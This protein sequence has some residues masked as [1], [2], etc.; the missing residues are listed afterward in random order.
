MKN[1]SSLA[2][3]KFHVPVGTLIDLSSVSEVPNTQIN[4]DPMLFCESVKDLQGIDFGYQTQYPLLYTATEAITDQIDDNKSNSSIQKSSKDS[5][6][7]IASLISDDAPLINFSDEVSIQTQEASF[8]EFQ[9]DQKSLLDIVIP[10]GSDTEEYKDKNDFFEIVGPLV[11]LSSDADNSV[12][13]P[14]GETNI[15]VTK[16]C[17]VHPDLVG[18]DFSK[19]DTVSLD[20]LSSGISVTE[21]SEETITD[22][23]VYADSISVQEIK[24]SF[25]LMSQFCADE[26][27]LCESWKIMLIFAIIFVSSLKLMYL[28]F[29]A[30]L[31]SLIFYSHHYFREKISVDLSNT[32]LNF[33]KWIF[34]AINHHFFGN[35]HRF[36]GLIKPLNIHQSAPMVSRSTYFKFF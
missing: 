15:S 17:L 19:I 26:A 6:I 12:L 30:I 25:S 2:K 7:F 23:S 27:D 31:T 3:R 10:L 8:Q 21:I 29:M 24:D 34:V 9:G 1:E 18:I 28:S 33:V 13:S 16:I 32:D 35:V 11:D 36:N 5:Q 22:F 14:S 20:S 4:M